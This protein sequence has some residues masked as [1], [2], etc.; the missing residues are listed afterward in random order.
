MDKPQDDIRNVTNTRLA[1]MLRC[2]VCMKDANGRIYFEK[3]QEA[4]EIV[5]EAARRLRNIDEYI[6]TTHFNS[7]D[8]NI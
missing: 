7:E 8:F 4:S 3:Q 2:I 5:C 1:E 6:P